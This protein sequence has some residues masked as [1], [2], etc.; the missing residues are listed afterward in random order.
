[1]RITLGLHLDSRQGPSRIDALG[2]PILGRMGLL[3]LL[4]TY[5]GLSR[6]EVTLAHRITSYL[7]HLRKHD[8]QARFYSRSLEADSVGT[9]AKLLAW[10][11]EWRLGGWNG[12]APA[13]SPKR[14]LDMVQ[15]E[16]VCPVSRGH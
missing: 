13:D 1:M 4:E 3:G 14:L 10:R 5:L 9:S 11:D 7:G 16:L 2:E 15:V 8:D 6:P 12:T